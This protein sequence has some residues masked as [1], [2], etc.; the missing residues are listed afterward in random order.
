MWP[1][2]CTNCGS[3]LPRADEDAR[4]AK[5]GLRC[6]EC[7]HR[8]D[9]SPDLYAAGVLVREG[10]EGGHEVLLVRRRVDAA[11]NPG[12][13][14]VP[15]LRV[16]GDDLRVTAARAVWQEAGL[17]ADVADVI[18]VL[19]EVSEDAAPTFMTWF[20]V[21]GEG[22][23][24]AGSTSEEVGFFPLERLPDLLPSE[25]LVLEGLRGRLGKQDDRANAPEPDLAVRLHRRK[26]R[27]RELL[28]AYTNELMRGAWVNDLHLRL[29]AHEE[30]E[31]ITREAAEQLATRAEVDE[32]RVWLPG[33]PDRCD[34]CPWAERC[35]QTGCLHLVT[36]LD[37]VREPDEEATLGESSV[38][39]SGERPPEEMRVPPLQG[40]PTA[41]VALLNE[42]IRAELPGT[43]VTPH[44]FEG[45]PLD[46][47]GDRGVL[48]L[49]SRHP[50]DPNARRLFEVVAL[51]VAALLRNAR[52]VVDLRAANEVKLGF[53]SRMSHELKTPLTAILGYSELLREELLA[54][55]NP[56]GADGA[57]TIEE[58]GRKLLGIVESILEIA[59]LQSGT[60]RFRSESLDL[61]SVIQERLPRWRKQAEGR[62]LSLSVNWTDEGPTEVWC[63]RA[64]LHQIL[65]ELLD[66]ALKF[67]HDRGEV[68]I[69]VDPGRDHVRCTVID[70]G[71]G[72]APADQ[73]RIWEPFQQVSEKIHLDYG[74]LGI[75]L[76][77]VKSLV[78]LQ[79]GRVKLDST[80][81]EGSRFSFTLP[82]RAPEREPA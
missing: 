81:G 30:P 58:S 76:A 70:Q 6:P 17:K 42:P 9:V 16:E 72:V 50:M 36:S 20:R 66:N 82:S 52:L 5:L 55:E 15:A 67:S 2:Y 14:G 41:D 56:L 27:Y 31:A 37:S 4:A 22:E 3:A 21:L 68:R 60:I 80:L 35:P 64:R 1:R 28:E 46:L 43:G 45:F 69:E 39:D 77:L 44:R 32:V 12:G 57:A 34:G 13:Y 48:G 78:V 73:E 47:G 24:V 23:P 29:T 63:D 40:V 25:R 8:N 74:G 79:G 75:G 38:A 71:I 11:R 7:S 10:A 19:N 49:I 54:A 51:H 61:L 18:D 65:D 62:E 59:K 53:I 33:P 26:E